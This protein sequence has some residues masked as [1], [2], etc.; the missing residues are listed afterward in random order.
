MTLGSL[1]DLLD[2][3]LGKGPIEFAT[4]M[5]MGKSISMGLVLGYKYGVRGLL[6][7]L[8]ADYRIDR[9]K[10]VFIKED[11]Y[12]IKF[13]DASLIIKETDPE[14]SMVL[15]GFNMYK[16]DITKYKLEDFD[17]KEVYLNVLD[18]YGMTIRYLKEIDLI[19]QMFIDPVTYELLQEMKE[20]TSVD[21]LL[22][23]AVE[24]L[25]TDEHP[26]E[27]DMAYMRVK[28][29]ERLS[30]MVYRELIRSLRGYQNSP[31]GKSRKLELHP[32]ACLLYTSPSPRDRQKSRMP[33]SA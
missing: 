17:S 2:N 25:T 6:R 15:N 5:I 12:A 31:E 11:E 26:R 13:A 10:R 21:G 23:R 30:E 27:T 7:K 19:F 16:R 32:K 22:L 29:Y 8:K 9:E 14:I 28:G 1:N 4:V 3:K 18:N 20:P 24:L 33:S